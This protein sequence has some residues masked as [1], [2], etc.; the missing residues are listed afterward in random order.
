M[1]FLRSSRHEQL[2]HRISERFGVCF[3]HPLNHDLVELRLKDVLAH[4]A[5]KKGWLMQSRPHLLH[6]LAKKSLAREIGKR[7]FQFRRVTA[8][9]ANGCCRWLPVVSS[10]E[11]NNAR[12]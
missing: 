4:A 12:I 2:I 11:V 8:A 3:R 10:H 5:V 7:L 6:Q 9:A 1:T